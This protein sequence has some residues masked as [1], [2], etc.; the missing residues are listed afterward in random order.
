VKARSKQAHLS[1]EVTSLP[2]PGNF[3]D[4]EKGSSRKLGEYG[5]ERQL[6]A[7]QVLEVVSLLVL[8]NQRFL[9]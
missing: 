5:Q 1:R 6:A 8:E 9:G 4:A 7:N 2:Q 3:R